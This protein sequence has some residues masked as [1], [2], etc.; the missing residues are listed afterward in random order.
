ML[1]A[2]TFSWKTS[3]FSCEVIRVCVNVN[4]TDATT[5]ATA[6]LLPVKVRA[7]E[8]RKYGAD[9]QPPFPPLIAVT[10]QHLEQHTGA[11][12]AGGRLGRRRRW[13]HGLAASTADRLQ[14]SAFVITYQPIANSESWS[15]SQSTMF[16]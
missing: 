6:L 11:C 13:R 16:H 8:R 2:N 12:R 15:V 3:I 4:T 14:L 7:R 5:G 9:V 1:S 10:E